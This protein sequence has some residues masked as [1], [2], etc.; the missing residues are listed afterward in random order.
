MSKAK[1]KDKVKL[2]LAILS[3][4]CCERCG[5]YMYEDF[6]TKKKVI[7]PPAVIAISHMNVPAQGP[8]RAPAATSNGPPGMMASSTCTV[9]NSINTIGP[10]MPAPSIQSAKESG[11]SIKLMRGFHMASVSPAMTAMESVKI[12]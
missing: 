10:H 4:G 1:I 3:G 7:I 6:L 12:R 5:V 8:N 2:E 11:F 9:F